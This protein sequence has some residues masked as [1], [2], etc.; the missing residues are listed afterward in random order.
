MQS[1]GILGLAQAARHILIADASRDRGENADIIDRRIGRNEQQEN[2]IDRFIVHGLIRNRSDQS[3]EKTEKPVEILEARMW[4]GEAL[5][6]PRRT[7]AL[8]RLDGLE[9]RLLRNVQ[10][11]PRAACQ[12]LEKL[13]LVAGAK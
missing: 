1:W 12:L 7:E 11:G 9:N 10:G 4:Q 6:E 5:P 13:R 2:E 3:G 8:P